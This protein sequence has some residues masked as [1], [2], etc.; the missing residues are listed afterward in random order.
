MSALRAVLQVLVF[1]VVA[2]N[3]LGG[4]VSGIWLAVLGEWG[5]IGWGIAG[6][7]VSHLVLSIA[8]LP[9]FAFGAGAAA[10]G[11]RKSRVG[12]L[13]LGGLSNLYTVAVMTAWCIGVLLFFLSQAGQ[14]SWIPVLIW[15]YGVALGPW[16]FLAQKDRQ[17]GTGEGSAILTIAAQVGYIAMM[18]LVAFQLATL[19]SL[20]TVFGG[21]M[22]L[23]VAVQLWIVSKFFD[24]QQAS[25][26]LS[27]EEKIQTMEEWKVGE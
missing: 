8:L 5:A 9:G 13:I 24:H 6:I 19:T 1:G 17:A 11:E 26:Q 4:V 12:T 14:E 22:L 3:W 7:F 27:V 20:V 15:S 21:I 18:G 10:L 23:P 16:M 2:L 25:P